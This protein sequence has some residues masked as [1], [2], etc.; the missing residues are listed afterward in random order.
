MTGTRKWH[1]TCLVFVRPTAELTGR[2][3]IWSRFEY[4]IR[5][6][7]WLLTFGASRINRVN[8]LNS[9]VLATQSYGRVEFAVTV[10][11]KVAAKSRILS[12][13]FGRPIATCCFLRAASNDP[14]ISFLA[15]KRDVPRIF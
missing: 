3:Q 7:I 13:A 12:E 9:P 6:L 2:Q 14:T 1:S 10:F 15:L 8:I 11:A 4:R 5:I